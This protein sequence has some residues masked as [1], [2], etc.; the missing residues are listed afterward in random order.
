MSSSWG[1]RI[2]VSIFG[3]SHTEAIG[4]NIDGLPAGEAINW[5]QVLVQMAR[6]APGQDK[7]ATTRK[8]SDTPKVLCGLLDG[9]TTGAPLCAI[10]E[11]ANQRPKDYSQLKVLPRPGHADYTAAVK[12]AGYQDVRGGGHFSGRLTAPLVFAGAVARQLLNRRGITV[13][14]HIR[15]IAGCARVDS[16][17]DP[18]NVSPML[19]ER[20][21][22][23]YFPVIDPAVK[24]E[25]RTAIE[26]ARMAQD[27]AG[28][29]VECAVAGLPVGA[30]NPMFAGVEN[31]IASLVFGIPAVKGI[32]FGAG[33]AVGDMNGSQ[34]NDAFYVENGGVKTRTNHA[35]GVLGGITSGMPLIFSA[36]FKPTPSISR[37]QDTVN[38][39]TMEDAKLKITGRHDPCI[40][41]RAAVALEAAACIAVLEL[42]AQS[43]ML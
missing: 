12:Y 2:R 10:I 17:L 9:V 23:E 16:A 27:S 39:D 37:E 30:G 5:Q 4:V 7:T 25:M 14:S 32:E 38:L 24:E 19:L 13:G 11:N 43:S 18:V 31:L 1:E 6:R 34:N 3:G 26:Q 40:V 42:L 41:P 33:F 20:L 22:Q 21:N 35:G 15:K 29:I 28:G 36:A 8:E